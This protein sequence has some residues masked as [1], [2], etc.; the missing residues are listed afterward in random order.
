MHKWIQHVEK[1]EGDSDYI[2]IITQL[3]K[4]SNF[5]L[6]LRQ[7]FLEKIVEEESLCRKFRLR[8]QIV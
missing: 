8:R 6:N 5:L 3:Y 7:M 2:E 4:S 1:P